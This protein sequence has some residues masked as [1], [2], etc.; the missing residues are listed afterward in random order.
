MDNRSGQ[1]PAFLASEVAT[2]TVGR[3][4]RTGNQRNLRANGLFSQS[5]SVRCCLV[6]YALHWQRDTNKF[7]LEADNT[8]SSFEEI[9]HP[10]TSLRKKAF[11]FFCV[12]HNETALAEFFLYSVM[13]LT[14]SRCDLWKFVSLHTLPLSVFLLLPLSTENLTDC[15]S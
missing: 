7:S 6:P 5:S 2:S 4:L 14:T 3:T 15:S 8:S 10:E 11:C 9:I 12:H 1:S 13:H